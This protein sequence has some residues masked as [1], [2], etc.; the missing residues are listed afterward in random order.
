MSYKFLDLSKLDEFTRNLW[1]DN[2]TLRAEVRRLRDDIE[3]LAKANK[4]LR[5]EVHRLEKENQRLKSKRVAYYP[6]A[7][8]LRESHYL[9]CDVQLAGAT[10]SN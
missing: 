5:D 1:Q 6:D 3:F 7:Q 10:G 2:Q 8:W 4:F 9:H